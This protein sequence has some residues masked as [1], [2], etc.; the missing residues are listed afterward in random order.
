MEKGMWVTITHIGQEDPETV[1]KVMWA[2]IT[3]IGQKD[4]KQEKQAGN[5]L[6]ACYYILKKSPPQ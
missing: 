3:H 2:T 5:K 6:P 4:Q 1:R